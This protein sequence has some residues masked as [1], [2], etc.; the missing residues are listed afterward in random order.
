MQTAISAAVPES[1]ITTRRRI[2][3][4]GRIM[5]KKPRPKRF[6]SKGRDRPGNRTGTR[7]PPTWRA[8][9]VGWGKLQPAFSAVDFLAHAGD[10]DHEAQ[11]A[12]DDEEPGGG[13]AKQVA[14]TEPVVVE[15]A[16]DEVGAEGGDGEFDVLYAGGGP[17]PMKLAADA[18]GGGLDHED[19]EGEQGNHAK[20]EDITV[21]Q[22]VNRGFH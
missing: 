16:D 5:G 2:A 22:A 21:F 6:K 15:F 1:E 7:R 9:T 13:V 8:R 11:H 10:E 18:H 3:P 19:A 20:G 17:L 14:A 4:R 12:G